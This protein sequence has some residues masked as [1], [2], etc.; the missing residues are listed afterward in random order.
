MTGLDRRGFLRLAGAVGGSAAIGGLAGCGQPTTAAELGPPAAAPAYAALTGLPRPDIAGSADGL[1]PSTYFRYPSKPLQSVRATPGD[2][3]AVSILTQTFSPIPPAVQNN[4]VWSNLNAE[5]GSEL[6]IQLV[7]QIDY[8]TKFA[9][10]VAGDTLP[11]L[12]FANPDFPRQPELMAARAADLSEHLA[13]DAIRDY[14]NLANIP[15]ACWDVGR[16]NG[17][18]YGLP[19]PRGSM[20]SGV[21]FRR[22]DLLAARGIAQEPGSFADFAD[23][24]REVT[25]ARSG[26]WALTAAPL[27]YIRNMLGI[28]NFWRFDGTTMQSWWT[29]PEQE[30]ALEAARSLF[31]DGLVNPDAYSSPNKKSWFGSG[32]A[33]FTDDAFTSWPQFYSGAADG[34]DLGACTIPA[35]DGGGRGNLWLSFPSYG[36][37][38]VAKAAADRVPT[39]LRI[40]DYLAAPFGTTEYLTV[41][42]GVEGPDYELKD[43]S[44]SA[45]KSGSAGSAL[46]VKYIV[47]APQVNFV[48]GH[49][50][51][52]KKLDTLLRKLLPDAVANDAVYLFSKTAADRFAR[53]NTR[54]ANLEF[55]II[56]GRKP[57]SAWREEIDPWWSRYG[58]QMADELTEAYHAAGRG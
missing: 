38:A 18:I 47:D 20:S 50:E 21:L 23:L 44:P 36:F 40:A 48:P 56:Q 10:V 26:V 6:K 17:R 33:Y 37:A 53:T 3:R 45:T 24:C 57:V 13:G 4:S 51:A 42:Y 54:I 2:G 52:A 12:F 16:F 43:G 34:F 19:S 25:D 14:P 46:G 1:I 31:A 7:P 9:T 8:A 11:D 15:S 28:A 41:R 22:D 32:K 58:R 35:F 49:P 5:L 39:L 30:Q 55:E 29:P 27:Q